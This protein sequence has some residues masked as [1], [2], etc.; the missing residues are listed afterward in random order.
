MY[1]ILHLFKE[2]YLDDVLMA[3]TETGID[4]AIILAGESFS[5]QRLFNM[6]LFSGFRKSYDSGKKFSH[7]IMAIAKKEDIDFMLKELESSD[8]HFIEDKIGEIVLLPTTNEFTLG[9][10]D[11]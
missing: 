1:M 6:P 10:K 2:R 5:H 11:E 9:D 7:V 4:D 8:I 3:I